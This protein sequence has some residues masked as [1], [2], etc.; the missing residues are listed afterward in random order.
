MFQARRLLRATSLLRARS[1]RPASADADLFVIRPAQDDALERL[2]REISDQHS[3]VEQ[4]D[5]R[6]I[7]AD[8]VQATHIDMSRP[9]RDQPLP[10]V[11]FQ[12]DKSN[13][14]AQHVEHT[15][16]SKRYRI[17]RRRWK[18]PIPHAPIQVRYRGH[19]RPSLAISHVEGSLDPAHISE[20]LSDPY[21]ILSI[22]LHVAH[23]NA[24]NRR[25]RDTLT[26]ADV[27]RDEISAPFSPVPANQQALSIEQVVARSIEK[28]VAV[29]SQVDRFD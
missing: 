1:L 18:V 21:P 11:L 19:A 4:A 23:R 2:R 9:V 7:I 8:H 29:A 5:Q 20:S 17:E 15:A 14:P 25:Q 10:M 27:D 16:R 24:A 28:I 12:A 22:D 13:R 6:Q 3:T 26:A